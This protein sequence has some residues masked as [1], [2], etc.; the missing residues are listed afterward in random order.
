MNPGALLAHTAQ[1]AAAGAPVTPDAARQSPAEEDQELSPRSVLVCTDGAASKVT[2]EAPKKT[3]APKL[4]TLDGT[5]APRN[6]LAMAV[7]REDALPTGVSDTSRLDG[8]VAGAGAVSSLVGDGPIGFLPDADALLTSQTH[9]L[10][11]SG[12]E[13]DSLFDHLLDFGAWEAG[14]SWPGQ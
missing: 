6:W 11:L 7:P 1:A 4:P 10:P 12:R 3:W 8:L 13:E 14:L 9:G 5:T 2:A